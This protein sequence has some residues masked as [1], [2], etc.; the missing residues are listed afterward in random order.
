MKGGKRVALIILTIVFVLLCS[1]LPLL[2]VFLTGICL[3]PQ[4]A[5]T[6]YG[7][8]PALYRHLEETEG[9][10]IIIVGNSN[11]AFGSDSAL[12]EQLLREGGL[13]YSVCNFG[14][15]GS[16][17]TKMML[18]IAM[19]E[20]EEGDIIILATELAGQS[21]STY[22]SAT[23]A[24]YALD[25]DM[26]LYFSFGKQEKMS[27]SGAYAEYTAKKLEYFR[28][29]TPA[30]PSGV[31]A[32]ASFD[33][34]GDL[35]NYVRAYNIMPGGY[36]AN[37]PLVLDSSLFSDTFV[38][39]LNSS[40]T[41]LKKR[42]VNL[43]LSFAPM[44][45]SAFTEEYDA[46]AFQSE[47]TELLDLR[48]IS[49]VSDYIMDKG[50]FYDSN[51]HLNS[52]GMK[53]RTVQLVNDI[54][55]ELGN[56]TKTEISLPDMP[57]AP[58]EGIEGEGDNSDKNCFTYELADGSYTIT[59]LTEEGLGKEELIIPYQVNGI[60]IS[61]F[62]EKTFKDNS[63]VKSITIQQN[64]SSLPDGCFNGCNSLRKVY[65]Q[66]DDPAD[67]SVGYGLFDGTSKDLIV[68]VRQSVLS[69]FTNNYFWGKYAE[70]LKAY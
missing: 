41:N 36:D 43:W 37:N 32:S 11:I 26:S 47:V 63:R 6:W 34:R 28:S 5:L 13:D 29:G 61:A 52:A 21:L 64:I 69:E 67:I 51:F 25:G 60:F 4:F 68:F 45:M 12:A 65:L 70:R 3:P 2:A 44:N 15:Y 23:E 59:G 62:D 10:K 22:F 35:K 57:V 16:L 38:S 8:Y 14:L 20:A 54:K 7:A 19:S 46:A 55:N 48:V 18:D 33:E 31:Y 56:S 39:Y 66:H 9:N 27:L 50:W 30:Q 58:D 40:A 49:D 42:G 53:V 24:W 17:G 1:M